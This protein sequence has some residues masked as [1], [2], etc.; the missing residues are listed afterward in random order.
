[1]FIHLFIASIK[2]LKISMKLISTLNFVNCPVL[3]IWQFKNKNILNNKITEGHLKFYE[4]FI[5]SK[6]K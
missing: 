3:D 4:N 6:N 2:Q 5:R 1:M